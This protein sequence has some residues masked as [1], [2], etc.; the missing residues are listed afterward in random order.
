MSEAKKKAK[1]QVEEVDDK[2]I[3]INC[4]S[5]K[6]MTFSDLMPFEDNPRE[7]SEAGFK[8]L[9]KSILEL[10]L[11]K[12]F[13]VWK[14]GNKVLGGN[15]RFRV[16]S[17]LVET[18]G[19][20]VDKLPVTIIDVDEG[21]ARVIV[22]RDNQSDGDW[23]YELL[24]PY[25]E[26]L[27]KFGVDKSLTGFSD[28]EYE[29]LQKLVASPEQLREKLEDMAKDTDVN[30]M[31]TKQFGVQ[32]KVPDED[33]PFWQA[34]MKKMKEETGTSEVWPNLRHV[35]AARYPDLARELDQSMQIDDSDVDEIVDDDPFDEGDFDSELPAEM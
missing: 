23:A 9:K 17:H 5:D 19:Y 22:L 21:A 32:F 7:L 28:R 1:P 4:T 24:A 10:G 20:K 18:E 6:Y 16:I 8:K 12:P 33:Y 13:L 27:E 30:E 35:L 11:F 2:K 14:K 31:M 25:L 3:K 29:D 15:Q 34:V 26:D